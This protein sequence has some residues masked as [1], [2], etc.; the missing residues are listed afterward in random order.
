[1][2]VVKLVINLIIKKGKELKVLHYANAAAVHDGNLL[3][4]K[5]FCLI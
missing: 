3:Y 5:A 2:L 1:M 4:I